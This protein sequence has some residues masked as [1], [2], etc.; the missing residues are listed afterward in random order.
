[1]HL[2]LFYTGWAVLKCILRGKHF[3]QEHVLDLYFLK[4]LPLYGFLTPRSGIIICYP[5]S[6][7][8]WDFWKWLETQLP[9]GLIKSNRYQSKSLLSSVFSQSLIGVSH[10]LMPDHLS[11]PVI[12]VLRAVCAYVLVSN[13]DIRKVHLTFTFPMSIFLQSNGNFISLGLI[14]VYW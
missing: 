9:K 4:T 8:S 3:S 7:I 10:G 2:L 11:R 6:Y 13:N 1:M 5:S 14:S 12:T